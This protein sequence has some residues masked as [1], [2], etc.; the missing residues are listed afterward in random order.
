M[1]RGNRGA[2]RWTPEPKKRV[3]T[4]KLSVERRARIK[5][6]L[7]AKYGPICQLCRGPIDM[8]IVGIGDPMRWSID[9]IIRVANGGTND[10]VNLRPAH[11]G[12]NNDRKD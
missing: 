7:L 1:S 10:M 5:R 12:C 4:Q 3:G 6:A 8:A 2:V 9:H 11:A